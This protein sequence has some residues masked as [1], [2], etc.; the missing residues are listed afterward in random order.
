MAYCRCFG[1]IMQHSCV[2]CAV[3][4]MLSRRHHQ[5][6]YSRPSSSGLCSCFP[7]PEGALL[8]FRMQSQTGRSTLLHP[9]QSSLGERTSSYC[10]QSYLG[11]MT[12]TLWPSSW[13][14]RPRAVTTSPMP[15]TWKGN[16]SHVCLSITKP[17]KATQA[18]SA[19]QQQHLE[20]QHKPCLPL[21]NK[22]WKGNTSWVCLLTKHQERQH[23]P[24]MPFNNT[25]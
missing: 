5:L 8:V 3:Q 17:G 19:I 16:T 25:T 18:G 6:Y 21:N 15:P 9:I 14:A 4:C 24:W 23:Q 10:I 12:S 7:S 11:R 2:V 22:P 20:R 1:K 13:T